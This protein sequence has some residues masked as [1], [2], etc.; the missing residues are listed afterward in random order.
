MTATVRSG[1]FVSVCL[2][3]MTL[4]PGMRAAT[5]AIP[6]GTLELISETQAIRPARSFSLGLKFDL[7]PGWHIYWVNPGD[8]G[9]PPRVSWQLPAAIKAGE[10]EW[11]YPQ[12]LP[13]FSA[14]D[15]GYENQVL[16][17]VPMKAGPE[18]Q[19]GPQNIAASV[20]VIVCRD[21]CIPGKARLSLTLPAAMQ[22]A[23]SAAKPLFEAARRKLPQ[24]P[25]QH[26]SF[27]AGDQKDS[28]RLIATV[29]HPVRQARFFPLQ[30]S[31]IENAAPQNVQASRTGFQLTLKKSSQLIKPIARLKGVL[32]LNEKAYEIDVPVK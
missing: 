32:V 8:A 4:S 5:I 23:D 28:F 20:K 15:F 2:L 13:A 1:H 11:P 18:L 19:N 21:I 10:I 30:E 14:M 27:R 12:P 7:E 9:E 26:W 16:L 17:L 24:I 25:P 31:Q 29:G 22:A 6:H 3:V